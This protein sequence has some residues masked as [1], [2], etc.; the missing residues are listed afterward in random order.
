MVMRSVVFLILMMVSQA[1]FALSTKVDRS[2]LAQNETLTLQIQSD[3]R[4]DLSDIDLTQLRQDFEITSRSTQSSFNIINGESKSST[5]LTLQLKPLRPGSLLIPEFELNGKTSR[6]ITVF[7]TEP[8]QIDNTTQDRNVF[9]EVEVDKKEITVGEQLLYTLRVLYATDLSNASLQPFELAGVEIEEIP[10]QRYQRSIDGRRY[11]VVERRYA[12]F[13]NKEGE[14]VIPQQELHAV[15][16]GSSRFGFGIDR[17]GR[18]SQ[19]IRIASDEQKVMV[20]PIPQGQTIAN[21]L[22][23]KRLSLNESWGTD[24]SS[25]RVGEPLLRKI[26]ITAEGLSSARL[27]EIRMADIDGLN[28]YPE[29][30]EL[31][32]ETTDQGVIGQRTETLAFIPTQEGRYTVPELSIKWWDTQNKRFQTAVLPEKTLTIL[33]APILRGQTPLSLDSDAADIDGGA[34]KGSDPLKYTDGVQSWWQ[35]LALFSTFAWVLTLVYL[36]STRNQ[37]SPSSQPLQKQEDNPTLRHA[38]HQLKNQ[39]LANDA[40]QAK[41][42]LEK[43]LPLRFPTLANGTVS[44]KAKQLGDEALQA[45]I[46]QLNDALYGNKADVTWQGAEL[47]KVVGRVNTLKNKKAKPGLAP[48]YPSRAVT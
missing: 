40:R 28:I 10:E 15:V 11:N 9:L 7:A 44:D 20:K 2:S 42:A 18:R 19:Q 45:Q 29:K 8:R 21:W 14:L 37:R 1:T 27:P 13:A 16:G 25:V 33:P 3:S 30:P 41:Q 35:Y 22:P 48:L 39:C 36:W 26:Q 34:I 5:T 17:F 43:W 38:Y 32:S 46:N 47:I 24:P 4:Q 6:S 23:A 12:I 31:K